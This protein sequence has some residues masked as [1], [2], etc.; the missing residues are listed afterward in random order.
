M[1]ESVTVSLTGCSN[2][3]V[4]LT[5]S[6][7]PRLIFLIAVRVAWL[8]LMIDRPPFSPVTVSFTRVVDGSLCQPAAWKVPPHFA[9]TPAFAALALLSL[10]R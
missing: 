7:V 1:N 8:N 6:L 4:T 10:S 3:A 5:V 9:Y 2:T